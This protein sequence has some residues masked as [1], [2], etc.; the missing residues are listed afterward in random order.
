MKK[1]MLWKNKYIAQ[2]GYSFIR[3]DV[4]IYSGTLMILACSNAVKQ[5]LGFLYSWVKQPRGATDSAWTD[6]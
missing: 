1:Q 3:L 2:V 4:H 5:H 6:Q